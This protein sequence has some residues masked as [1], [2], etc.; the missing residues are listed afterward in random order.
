M[1]TDTTSTTKI[2]IGVCIGVFVGGLLLRGYERAME[3]ARIEEA[4]RQ[5]KALTQAA[6]PSQAQIEDIQRPLLIAKAEQLA[7]ELR[8]QKTLAKSRDDATTAAQAATQANADKEH[9]WTRYYQRPK[10][11]DNPPND[12]AFVECSNGR[13]KARRLF[14]Q[15]YRPGT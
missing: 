7:A 14:E 6:T 12:Q 9:A 10:E 1:T 4:M 15:T 2:A 11:C 3:Q 8:L 13:I 5:F